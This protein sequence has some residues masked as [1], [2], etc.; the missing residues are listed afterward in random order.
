MTTL[1]DRQPPTGRRARTRPCPD[2]SQTVLVGLDADLMAATVTV[3]PTPI[4]PD[5]ETTEA[6][7]GRRTAAWDAAQREL[8]FRDHWRITGRPAN[9]CTVYATHVCNQEALL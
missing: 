5:R 3:T 7:A 1:T 4:T 9:T 6:E 8:D 2:C